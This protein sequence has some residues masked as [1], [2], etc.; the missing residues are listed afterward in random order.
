MAA[1]IEAVQLRPATVMFIDDN[2]RDLAEAKAMI[3]ELQLEDEEF[4]PK[5]LADPRFVGKDDT[6]LSRLKQYKLL[7]ARREAQ[8][9][10]AAEG[11]SFSEIR[12]SACA[13]ITIWKM[14][15]ISIVRL[16]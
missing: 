15:P 7:E 11:T 10:W 4:I 6:D 13:S 14:L 12:T 16:N 8:R 3:P 1:L 9:S 5:L 2:P